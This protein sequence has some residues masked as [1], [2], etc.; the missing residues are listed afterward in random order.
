MAEDDIYGSKAKYERFVRNI[1]TLIIEPSKRKNPGQRR[2]AKYFCR[3][4]ANLAYFRRINAHFKAVDLSYVRRLRIFN[5]LVFVCDCTEKDLAACGRHDMNL[6]MERLHEVNKTIESKQTVI[7][8][9]KALW[10]V[11]FPELDG[12]GR[13]DETLTPYVVRH[14]SARMD[15]S[16]R[17][18]RNDYFTEEE[19][20]KIINYLGHDP[21]LQAFFKI[22]FE[23]YARPQA[24]LYLKIGDVTLLDD[25]AEIECRAHGK[26]GPRL[27]PPVIA[28]YPY[29][30]KWLKEHP[31]K[32]DKNAYLFINTGNTNRLKQ[33]RVEAINNALKK[34]CKDLQID[35]PIRCYSFKRT[36]INYDAEND[37]NPITVM[38]N[39]GWTSISRFDSYKKKKPRHIY[40]RQLINKG[41]KNE[42]KPAINLKE[43][44]KCHFCNT[45]VGFSEV[46]CP[47]CSRPL[48][49]Q[50]IAE[51]AEAKEQEIGQL[52]QEI[53]M[54][55]KQFDSFKQQVLAGMV[56]EIEAYKKNVIAGN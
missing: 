19:Y 36:T 12:Q 2:V 28:S 15:I 55:T 54:L 17:V 9:I 51:K 56:S 25:Y 16:K 4:P 7:K 35:K 13:P 8:Q 31:L 48:D 53:S 14:L 43:Q 44:K 20:L 40:N 29:L 10:R 27:F 30:I 24:M 47:Q 6:I 5:T 26:E 21:R 38:Y 50:K 3:N 49:Q 39:A 11:L 46:I 23:C 37:E 34:A 32:H 22:S 52:K 45:P 33:L 18:E 42:E 41:L 1:D